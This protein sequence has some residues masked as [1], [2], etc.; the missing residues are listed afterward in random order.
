VSV[1]TTT[2]HLGNKHPPKTPCIKYSVNNTE[3]KS[4]VLNDKLPQIC[5]K[6]SLVILQ[7][8]QLVHYEPTLVTKEIKTSELI[9]KVIRTLKCLNCKTA[10]VLF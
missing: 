9:T 8:E 6:P 1:L 7:A 3:H 10:L 5:K 4:R 2:S